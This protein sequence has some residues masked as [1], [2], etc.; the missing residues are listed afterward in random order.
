MKNKNYNPLGFYSKFLYQERR[1]GTPQSTPQR[2]RGIRGLEQHF[3]TR[4]AVEKY[5][6]EILPFPRGVGY[7]YY[8]DSLRIDIRKYRNILKSKGIPL[9][10][11]MKYCSNAKSTLLRSL[12]ATFTRSEALLRKFA[13]DPS[14]DVKLCVAVNP[15]TFVYILSAMV[16]KIRFTTINNS[17]QMAGDY[18]LIIALVSNKNIKRQDLITIIK[19]S[20]DPDITTEALNNRRIRDRDRELLLTPSNNSEIRI[21]A[22]EQIVRS[23]SISAKFKEMIFNRYRNDSLARIRYYVAHNAPEY[24]LHKM[25]KVEI[26]A[27]IIRIIISNRRLKRIPVS[28]LRRMLTNYSKYAPELKLIMNSRYLRS[29]LS[30]SFD[31]AAEIQRA[32]GAT[33]ERTRKRNR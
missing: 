6:D 29:K 5:L 33:G 15:Y 27:R 17:D 26:N 16:K 8:G 19:K 18:R 7:Y 4:A 30:V 3:G 25:L 32:G 13:K 14:I 31:L 24:I 21:G 22:M 28:F 9:R 12:V 2:F 20:K 11:F 23:R 10:K 1:S